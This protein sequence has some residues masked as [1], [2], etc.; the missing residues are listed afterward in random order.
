M[1]AKDPEK[2]DDCF[3]I[4]YIETTDLQTLVGHNTLVKDICNLEQIYED[5][6]HHG[7]EFMAVIND[8]RNVLGICSREEVGVMLGLRYGRELFARKK[9]SEQL[10]RS[11]TQVM[12]GD[13]ITAVLD[14]ALSRSEQYYFD[15]VVLVDRNERYVGLI[16]MRTLILLQ[17]RFLAETIERLEQHRR[18]IEDRQRQMEEDLVL[19]SHL[20]QAMLQHQSCL[21]QDGAATELL[22]F[23][24]N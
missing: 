11:A 4:E 8:N 18:E 17:H 14:Q 5:F 21:F 9:V 24:L 12:V 6:Q 2:S 20:Q 15:D 7:H 3:T 22:P 16:P 10:S 1:P 23:R 13:R 19:A